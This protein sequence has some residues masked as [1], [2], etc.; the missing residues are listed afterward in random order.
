MSPTAL[1]THTHYIHIHLCDVCFLGIPGFVPLKRCIY[2]TANSKA[3]SS[4]YREPTGRC[5]ATAT[6]RKTWGMAGTPFTR[7]LSPKYEDGKLLDQPFP[8]LYFI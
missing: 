8:C 3:C 5:T 1:H 2:A 7:I 4:T 6:G